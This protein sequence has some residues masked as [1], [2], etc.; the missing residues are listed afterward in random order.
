MTVYFTTEHEWLRLEGDE[1][2]VGI[3][4]HAA[5]ALGELVFVEIRPNGT[6]VKAGESAAVAESVKAASDIYAPVDG[7]L[8]DHN[9]ALADNPAQVN[10]D[11]E[12]E[13]WIFRLRLTTKDQL[14]KLMD[15]AA[16]QAFIHKA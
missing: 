8:I 10:A 14:S 5:E 12:G 9:P 3:T 13:G 15:A 16:Y 1:A 4:Q 6:V 7:T 2:V 11:P